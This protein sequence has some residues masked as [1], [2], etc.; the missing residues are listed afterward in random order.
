MGLTVGMNERGG[1]GVCCPKKNSISSSSTGGASGGG[2]DV[3]EGD[4]P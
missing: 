3:G 2:G 1:E 4:H